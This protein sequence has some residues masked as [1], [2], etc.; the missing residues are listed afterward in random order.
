MNASSR[1]LTL[2]ALPQDYT[3][4]KHLERW[5]KAAVWGGRA[6]SVA[7]PSSYSHRFL[8]AMQRVLISSDA[9]EAGLGCR[10]CGGGSS[11][12]VAG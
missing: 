7:A 12:K 11:G 3:L 1:M 6:V 9:A 8:A 4:R 5:S 2:P 10:E